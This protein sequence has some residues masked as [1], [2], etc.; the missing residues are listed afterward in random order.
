MKTKSTLLSLC[1]CSIA[2]L[3]AQT[4]AP[5]KPAAEK[6]EEEPKAETPVEKQAFKFF[7]TLGAIPDILGA[8]KD[9]AT[10]AAAET[11]LDEM[12]KKLKV[13]EAALLKLDVPDNAARKKLSAKMKLKQNAM[14][15]KLEPV[16]MGFQTLPPEVA[17]KLGPMMQKFG[18]KM[19]EVEPNIKKYITP[20][21]EKGE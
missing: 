4:A 6:T 17:A 20:D 5:A 11:K 19:N 14:N 9:D 12:F 15:K 7:D 18:A 10:M 3:P 2:I 8:I 1:A 16:M 21:K 13:A